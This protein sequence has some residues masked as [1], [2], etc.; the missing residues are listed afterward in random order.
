MPN[1]RAS[2]GTSKALRRQHNAPATRPP[3]RFT[4]PGVTR[5]GV[6]GRVLMRQVVS[7]RRSNNPH[8]TQCLR[9]HAVCLLLLFAASLLLY[10]G[11]A[12]YCFHRTALVTAKHQSS[13]GSVIWPASVAVCPLCC[14]PLV[15]SVNV[16][17]FLLS[18]V[19]VL[20]V[21]H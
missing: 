11:Y 15:F 5:R 10:V 6:L 3:R 4:L 16:L 9:D 21:A 12:L 18:R 20:H 7:V 17:I 1:K 19:C 14:C 2:V 13:A 8:T